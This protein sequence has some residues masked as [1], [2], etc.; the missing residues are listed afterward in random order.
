MLPVAILCGGKGTRM[1][2]SGETLP[3]PLVEVGGRPILWHVMSLY[4]S[5]GFRRFELLLGRGA[6]RIEAFATALPREWEVSCLDTGLDTP[7]GG[8]LAR[9]ADRLRGALS[10]SPTPTASPT[11]TCKRCSPSTASMAARRP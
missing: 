8:R 5:Q 3:K 11:S 10:A 9:A 4:A 6:D 7:T 1:R 2:E